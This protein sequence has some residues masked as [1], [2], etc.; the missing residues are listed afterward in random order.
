[1]ACQSYEAKILAAD[2]VR[3]QNASWL[4]QGFDLQ[5]KM[6]PEFGKAVGTPDTQYAEMIGGVSI[7]R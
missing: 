3:M 6:R 1:M 2:D 7:F 4:I 5:R